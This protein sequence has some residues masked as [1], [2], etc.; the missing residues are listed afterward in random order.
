[1]ARHVFQSP[2]NPKSKLLHDIDNLWQKFE[3]ITLKTNHRQGE[4]REY[5]D[6]LNR[7]RVAKVQPS[8]EDIAVLKTRVFPRDSTE[9]PDDALLV[10]GENKIVNKVNEYKLNKLPGELIELNAVVYSNTRGNFKPKIDNAGM[11]KGTTLKFNLLLKK[12]C[13]VMLTH[14][15]DVCDGLTNGAMGEAVDFKKDP[16]GKIKFVLVKFDN[17]Y[18]GRERRKQLNFDHEYPG[19]AVTAIELLEF[20]FTIK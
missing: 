11:I 18:C 6:L 16:K 7:I 19:Q 8:E 9:L 4:E 5:A 14:N 13:R 1:M 2:S 12:G 17:D 3:V 15:L 10:S 20:D